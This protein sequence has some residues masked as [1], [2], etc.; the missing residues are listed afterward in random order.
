MRRGSRIRSQFVTVWLML[1]GAVQPLVTTAALAAMLAA[2]PLTG[3]PP[4]PPPGAPAAEKS[5]MARAYVAEKLAR[6]QRHLKLQNW[7]ISLRLC[8]P[9]ELKPRTMGNIHW[10][11][12]RHSA[13]IR[14]LDAAHY[15]LPYRAML[16]DMEFTIVHELVHLQ[17]AS[18]PRSEASRSEEEF[19]VN[20]IAEALLQLDRR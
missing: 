15:R 13:V 14:V 7:R 3:T 18:L 2:F 1:R 12:N 20:R 11:R 5:R 6:W 9:S 8:P 17:L 4:E 10:D 19:A 16:D